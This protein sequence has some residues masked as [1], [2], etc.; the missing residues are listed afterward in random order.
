M[1]LLALLE[2]GSWVV[3]MGLKKCKLISIWIFHIY[4]T[5]L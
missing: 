4:D 1:G 5:F 2:V 3:V